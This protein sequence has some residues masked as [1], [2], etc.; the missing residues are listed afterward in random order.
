M[1]KC[2]KLHLAALTLLSAG[3]TACAPEPVLVLPPASLA[4]CADEPEAPD[5]PD[6][7][8]SAETQDRR[9]VLTLAYVLAWR[10]AWGDCRA[11]VD[12]LKAWRASAG[13]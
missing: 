5:I 3:L 9:D 6:R 12:G 8:G 10:S 1:P 2:V 13:R 11:A 7:D 4:T